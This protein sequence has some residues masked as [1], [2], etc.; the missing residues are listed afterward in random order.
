MNEELRD[1]IRKKFA[2]NFEH[3]QFRMSMGQLH[4]HTASMSSVLDFLA[5]GVVEAAYQDPRYLLQL[6]GLHE[7]IGSMMEDL[8]RFPGYETTNHYV[9]CLTTGTMIEHAL[10]AVRDLQQED[11]KR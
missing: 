3:T 8:K 10:M 9:W 7:K 6:M 11:L 5:Q 1:R 4:V 2:D